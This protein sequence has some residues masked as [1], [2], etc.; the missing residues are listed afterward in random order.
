MTPFP[1]F[2]RSDVILSGQWHFFKHL[3]WQQRVTIASGRSSTIVGDL[4]SLSQ[5]DL[6]ETNFKAGLQGNLVFGKTFQLF[7]Y[8]A[9]CYHQES[10]K[11][12]KPNS[13]LVQRIC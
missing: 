7:Y 13:S 2:P 12:L 11:T 9:A 5:S 4:T 8:M 3:E 10:L 6:S 1:D